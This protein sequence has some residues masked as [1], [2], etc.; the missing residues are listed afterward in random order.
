MHVNVTHSF[1]FLFLSF[2]DIFLKLPFAFATFIV[3]TVSRYL[4]T[5]YLSQVQS[6]PDRRDAPLGASLWLNENW[7]K[8]EINS[9]FLH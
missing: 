7:R 9:H 1:L 4:P 5:F 3:Y 2:A 8:E 6:H